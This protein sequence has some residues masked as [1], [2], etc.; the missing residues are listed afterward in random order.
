M[1]EYNKKTL[2]EALSTLPEYEPPDFVWDEIAD[3]ASVDAESPT[4]LRA[5]SQL[6]DYEPPATVWDRILQEISPAQSAKITSLKR[7]WLAPVAVAASLALLVAAYFQFFQRPV[8]EDAQVL[9]MHYS[10]ETVDPLLLERDWD[11]DDD[12]FEAFKA[13]CE[14]KEF[15]CEQPEFVQLRSELEELTAAKEE[16]SSVLGDYGSDPELVMQIKEIEL[17]RTDLLKK[18]MVMLI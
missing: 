6:P 9:A 17:E 2:I 3:K 8:N 4:L 5:I 7:A 18:I 10:T 15:I 12:A 13:L 14:A 16:L 11:E 1:K